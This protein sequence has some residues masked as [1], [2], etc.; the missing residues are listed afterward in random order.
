MVL[1]T[2]KRYVCGRQLL[3]LLSLA[4]LFLALEEKRAE[5]TGPH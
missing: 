4:L 2:T 1:K 5:E 3:S